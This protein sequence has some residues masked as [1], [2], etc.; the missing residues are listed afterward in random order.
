MWLQSEARRHYLD[1]AKWTYSLSGVCLI[2]PPKAARLSTRSSRQRHCCMRPR[3][4]CTGDQ[5]WGAASLAAASSRYLSPA[6]TFQIDSQLASA[7][8]TSRWTSS[9]CWRTAGSCSFRARVCKPFIELRRGMIRW[10]GSLYRDKL[11]GRDFRRSVTKIW[12]KLSRSSDQIICS[13][14]W[15]S[16]C[17]STQLL[18]AAMH[19]SYDATGLV[20]MQWPRQGIS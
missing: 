19:Q 5:V 11:R 18:S 6:W 20:A 3:S 2:C 14:V 10:K 13:K 17:S 7:A 12:G 9:L 1:V 8:E 16:R 15:E 4:P